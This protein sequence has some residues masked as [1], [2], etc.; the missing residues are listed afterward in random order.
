MAFLSQYPQGKKLVTIMQAKEIVGVSR[1]TIYLWMQKNK[2]E[3]IKTAGGSIRIIED[4]LFQWSK[5]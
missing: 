3:W 5:K 1:R 2:I 4:S